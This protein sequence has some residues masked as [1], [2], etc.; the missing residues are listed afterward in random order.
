MTQDAD[1][2]TLTPTAQ[3]FPVRRLIVDVILTGGF[4]LFMAVILRPH[5]PSDHPFWIN[6]W[7]AI[8]AF[9]LSVLFF[10][11]LQM[12]RLVLHDKQA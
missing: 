12:F 1:P 8:T 11:A 7:S 3:L 9:C 6:V 2:H 5:V 10:I 4:W